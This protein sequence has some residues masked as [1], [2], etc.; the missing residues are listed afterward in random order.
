MNYERWIQWF[1]AG[2]MRL[3]RWVRWVGGHWTQLLRV[4]AL[5]FILFLVAT[6]VAQVS[7]AGI[8]A[9]LLTMMGSAAIIIV[10]FSIDRSAITI[11]NVGT[12][13]GT[14]IVVFGGGY[15]LTDARR[16]GSINDLSLS[17]LLTNGLILLLF[18]Y[19]TAALIPVV[20]SLVVR[21]RSR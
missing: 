12:I 7:S 6:A 3:L 1:R 20:Y 13:L 5:S 4:V 8:K 14:V 21:I 9:P 19:V 10:L 16:H 17:S 11:Q 18:V 15:W 2:W